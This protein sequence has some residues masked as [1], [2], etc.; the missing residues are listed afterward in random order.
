MYMDHINK[1]IFART[2]DARLQHINYTVVAP[3]LLGHA[4]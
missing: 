1:T 3:D 2:V 4:S